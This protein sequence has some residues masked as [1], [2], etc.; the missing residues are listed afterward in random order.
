MVTEDEIG[1]ELVLV[2]NPAVLE[3]NGAT[4]GC[5]ASLRVQGDH[6]F[7]CLEADDLIGCW[8]P[9]YSKDALQRV[10][11]STSGRTG[12]TKWVNGTFHYHPAQVWRAPH[13][14]V[15]AAAKAARD[16]SRAGS[17]NKIHEDYIPK[18]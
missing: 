2:L 17:R 10:T 3:A 13:T 16:M 7:L 18:L 11:I 6:F 4:C 15:V 12:H 8:L 9:M 14:A 5:A 1:M